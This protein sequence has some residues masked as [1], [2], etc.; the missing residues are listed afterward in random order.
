MVVLLPDRVEKLFAFFESMWFSVCACKMIYVFL[1][2][3]L[4][5]SH[6]KNKN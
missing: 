2:I 3:F 6:N 4:T 1:L 5:F